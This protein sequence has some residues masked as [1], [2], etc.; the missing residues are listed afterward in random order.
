MTVEKAEEIQETAR[1]LYRALDCAG[2]A[3]VDMFL[4]KDGTVYFNEINTIPGFTSL[5]RFPKMLMATG[6]TFQEV[7]ALLLR[8]G[9]P[10]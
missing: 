9:L 1:K 2:F 4:A 8:K 3:R 6:M 5:S 7:V 10:Q